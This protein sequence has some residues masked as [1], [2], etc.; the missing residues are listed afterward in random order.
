MLDQVVVELELEQLR[1]ERGW[2]LYVL[3]TVLAQA[4]SA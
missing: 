4:E 3:Y 1:R 2:E